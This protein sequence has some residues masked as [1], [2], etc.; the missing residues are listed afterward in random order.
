MLM[1][2]GE[3]LALWEAGSPARMDPET[4]STRGFKTFRDDLAHMPFLAHPRV[5]PDGVIWNIGGGKD[6][7]VWKLNANGSLNKA[8]VIK[9]PRASYYHD[10]TAT[11][12]HLVIVLQPWVQEEY[13]FPLSTGMV[14]R[15]EQGTQVLVMDK[16]DLTK[17]RV[18]ELPA[19]SFFHLGDAWE[20]ADG[21]IRFD[22]AFEADPTF[23][24]KS[25]SA[26]LRG[27][28]IRAPR[29]M[30][31]Q[32]ALHPNG[33][34][35][36][37]ASK[38]AAEFPTIDK[39]YAGV[40]RRYTNHVGHYRDMPFAHGVGRW[41]WQH[42]RDDSFDFGAHHLVEE[43]LFAPRGKSE[44]EGWLV[45]TTLNLKSRATELHILDAQRLAS[46]PLATWRAAVAMPHTFHGIFV[47]TSS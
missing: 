36:M 15:P 18:F 2:G 14:W 12:R 34:T 21:T 13:K 3:L 26:L 19:F 8:E 25:A 39:R 41:D 6:C 42:G 43:F 27:E 16:D 32:V 37:L 4:L 11:A 23:G 7:I 20:E 46:G 40:T 28:Y 22:G 44:G 30:L 10:L 29:P 1:A 9:L 5:Q 45:G 38:V 31:T 17:R 24:Q 33:R 47:S 35:Q